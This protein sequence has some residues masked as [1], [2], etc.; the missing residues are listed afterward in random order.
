MKIGNQLGWHSWCSLW[1]FFYKAMRCMLGAF[2]VG[3]PSFRASSTFVLVLLF[4][5]GMH[6]RTFGTV[7]A[8][9]SCLLVSAVIRRDL[10]GLALNGET[11]LPEIRGP[12]AEDN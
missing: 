5:D 3:C 6:A 7:L 12:F 11:L 1:R 10:K 4:W 2:G 9:F 8:L